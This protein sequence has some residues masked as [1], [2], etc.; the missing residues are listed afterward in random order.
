MKVDFDA[1]AL[2]I[3]KFLDIVSIKICQVKQDA[4]LFEKWEMY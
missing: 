3:F 2:R 1:I 4:L